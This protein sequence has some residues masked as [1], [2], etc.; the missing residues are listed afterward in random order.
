MRLA[1]ASGL[2]LAA[3]SSPPSISL[4]ESGALVHYAKAQMARQLEDGGRYLLELD[5]ATTLDPKTA[6]PNQ[7][8][9]ALLKALGR[10]DDARRHLEDM[11]RP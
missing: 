8:Y 9:L 6:L 4:D 2:L 3:A 5:Q 10:N 11:M 1:L 7:E